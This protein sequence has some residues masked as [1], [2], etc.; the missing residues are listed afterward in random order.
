MPTNTYG[1]IQVTEGDQQIL[2]SKEGFKCKRMF[3]CDG[4]DMSSPPNTLYGLYQTNTDIPMRGDPHPSIIIPANGLDNAFQADVFTITAFSSTQAKVIV[5]YAVLNAMTQEP[6]LENNNNQAF[7]IVSSSV[8]SQATAVDVNGFPLVIP[9]L[10]GGF[11]ENN[12]GTAYNI[13]PSGI[14]ITP[15]ATTISPGVFIPGTPSTT[16]T[17]QA[18]FPTTLI[19][20][21]RRE[22]APMSPEPYI[23]YLNSNPMSILG[24]D[25]NPGRLLM[26][27]LE[28]ESYDCGVS[29]QVTYELQVAPLVS[30]PPGA[31]W[32]SPA[33]YDPTFTNKMSGWL[34]GQYYLLPSG[35]GT[36]PNGSQA[37]PI[38]DPDTASSAAAIQTGQIPPDAV[39]LIFQI[40]GSADFG[41]LF[42]T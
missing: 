29:Y 9:Y 5:E 42:L 30:V 37:N 25:Y 10:G 12:P 21:V 14:P 17:A 1:D 35:Q 40:Y 16:V 24:V 34:Y 8:H 36:G 38:P 23:G 28:S 39:P 27:R 15:T 26:S 31:Q 19:R 3:I 33:N 18:Q 22:T 6:S 20:F 4:V 2:Y 7:I 41:S 13:A 32:I 11:P